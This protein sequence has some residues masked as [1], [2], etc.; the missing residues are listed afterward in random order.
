MEA[1]MA[2]YYIYIYMLT[3]FHLLHP[4]WKINMGPDEMDL[5]GKRVAFSKTNL[6]M[7]KF[8]VDL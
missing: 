5:R 3:F 8:H 1:I 6:V 7:F 2:I 4:S